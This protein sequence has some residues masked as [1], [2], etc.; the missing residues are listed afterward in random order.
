MVSRYGFGI[1][2]FYS[3]LYILLCIS[4]G[5]WGLYKGYKYD[6]LHNPYFIIC[7]VLFVLSAFRADTVGGDLERYLPH[8]ESICTS[9]SLL[10][11]IKDSNSESGFVVFQKILGYI[12]PTER[13]FIFVTSFL[14]LIGPFYFI[15]RYSPWPIYS[16]LLYFAWGFYSNTFNNVRQSIAISII[17]CSFPFIFDRKFVK[18]LIATVIATTFHSSAIFCIF[19]YFIPNLKLKVRNV[20]VSLVFSFAFYAILGIALIKFVLDVYWT[21]YDSEDLLLTGGSGMGRFAIYAIY[22][23]FLYVTYLICGGGGNSNRSIYVD[24]LMWL[25]V[26]SPMVQL[27]ATQVATLTRLTFYY[28]IPSVVLVPLVLNRIKS[29][30]MKDIISVSLL[31][32]MYLYM[33]LIVYERVQ[34]TMSNY[35]GVI[36]YVFLGK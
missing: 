12:S 34:G 35:Q 9:S 33:C 26:F 22:A 8:F 32:I 21:R 11:A 3:F 6:K 36:P 30:H 13:A 15:W 20:I 29:I 27:F 24:F 10:E 23:T 1:E 2:S 18:Y 31:F 28:F 4:G 19:M 7:G 16:L 17:L 5:L 25:L 14:S